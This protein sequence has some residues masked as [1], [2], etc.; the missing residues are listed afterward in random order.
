MY[1]LI[2][3][4]FFAN[5]LKHYKRKYKSVTKDIRGLL[6]ELASGNLVGDEI[7]VFASQMGTVCL[8]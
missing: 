7:Q 5:E 3:T 2:Y 4:D 8:K 1:N 6:E